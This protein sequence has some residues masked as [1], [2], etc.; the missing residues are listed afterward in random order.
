MKE[1]KKER[2]VKSRCRKRHPQ[3]P[4]PL[5]WSIL[6]LHLGGN[7]P[8]SVPTNK[9]I[10][11]CS[12]SSM[13]K[14]AEICMCRTLPAFQ[15]V[16]CSTFMQSVF[17][18]SSICCIGG[19]GALRL[20]HSPST[21][22]AFAYNFVAATHFV[23]SSGHMAEPQ[24]VKCAGQRVYACHRDRSFDPRAALAVVGEVLASRVGL[25]L[26]DHC[27]Y[28]LGYLSSLVRGCRVWQLCHCASGCVS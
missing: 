22:P 7:F 9:S 1:R 23:G 15:P 27:R 13:A 24:S 12:H 16:A 3:L 19:R 4:K 11:V 6:L 17:C 14:S 8:T 5:A 26:C 2:I 21:Q 28:T 18:W 10:T 25:L 20:G